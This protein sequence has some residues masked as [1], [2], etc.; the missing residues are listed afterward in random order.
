MVV[1]FEVVLLSFCCGFV[2][3]SEGFVCFGFCLIVLDLLCCLL[4]CFGLGFI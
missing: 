2:V 1:Y 4:A 3:C